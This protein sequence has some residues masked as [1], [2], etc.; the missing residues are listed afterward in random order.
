MGQGNK[1]QKCLTT[2]KE[3]MVMKE[4][5]EGLLGGNFATK[6]MQKNNWM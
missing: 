4:L 6:S 2:I 3:Q 5:H 1:L